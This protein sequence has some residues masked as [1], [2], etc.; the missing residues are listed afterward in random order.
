MRLLLLE[1]IWVVRS[2]CRATEVPVGSQHSNSQAGS[3][4]GSAAASQGSNSSSSAAPASQNGSSAVSQQAG[5][6][7][8]G[9]GRFSAKAVACRFRS[10]LQQ[11]MRRD[12][13]RV[14]VDVRLG[15]G[16]PLSWLR[17]PTPELTLLAFWRK[18]GSLFTVG[19]D[20][21]VLVAVSTAGL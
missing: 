2:S 15:A 11:Q 21:Q 3:R 14:G 20:G 7:G 8:G 5:A 16:I 18:W 17:G 13:R 10:Q 9:D 4:D 1:S 6:A 12:W 19:D